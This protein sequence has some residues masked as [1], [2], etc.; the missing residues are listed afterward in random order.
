MMGSEPKN[1]GV[2]CVKKK[3]GLIGTAVALAA[4]AAAVW[5]GL[6]WLNSPAKKF[7][8]YHQDFVIEKILSWTETTVDEQGSGNFSGALTVTGQT[9]DLIVN[10]ILE[11][12]AL[13]LDVNRQD[14]RLVAA[15]DLVLLG[16]DVL[17]VTATYDDGRIGLLL[18]EID[19]TY[20]VFDT[21]R[22]RAGRMENIQQVPRL[23]GSE[24]RDLLQTY[25]DVVYTTVNDRNVKLARNQSVALDALGSGF[26]GEIYTFQPRAEDI[27]SMLVKLAGH[28]EDSEALRALVLEIPN[29][30]AALR[31]LY[32][33]VSGAGE[34][35]PERSPDEMLLDLADVMRDNAARVGQAVEDSGFTWTLCVE[36]DAVRAIRLSNGEGSGLIYEAE[37]DASG[38]RREALSAAVKGERAVTAQRAFTE[39]SARQS[40]SITLSGK[41]GNRVFGFDLDA[42]QKSLFGVPYGTYTLSAPDGSFSLEVAPGADG[43]VDHR[44]S[45]ERPDG[46]S[47]LDHM[48]LCINAD[49][50]GSPVSWPVQSPTD[51]SGYSREELKA[52]FDET[53]KKLLL[54]LLRELALGSL[55]W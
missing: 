43:G 40:G 16:R 23:S 21:A 33:W 28:L 35:D 48:S 24:V 8:A 4:I 41:E 30:E 47:W 37:E 50:G 9:D 5:L 54:N 10:N 22:L 14:G 7:I 38:G 17:S 44:L 55:G 34:D 29:G 27:E 11:N 25:L 13:R 53:G 12:A 36:E 49:G 46:D 19:D 20:Y 3:G 32:R 52:L 45:V 6:G 31:I 42:S 39:G 1:A 15:G 18:P 51:I 2:I 26:T